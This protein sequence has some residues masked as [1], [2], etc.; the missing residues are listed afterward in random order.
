VN[1]KKFYNWRDGQY[2]IETCLDPE[3]GNR[4]VAA[5]AKPELIE[6]LFVLL[7]TWIIQQEA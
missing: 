2:I 7:D 4:P 1:P 5:L 3:T 6:R